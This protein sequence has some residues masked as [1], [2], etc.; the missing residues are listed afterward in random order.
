MARRRAQQG[1]SC[2]VVSRDACFLARMR[3]QSWYRTSASRSACKNG[4]GRAPIRKSTVLSR[5]SRYSCETKLADITVTIT[6]GYSREKRSMT[7]VSSPDAIAS[8]D[9]IRT[10]P[11][12]GSARVSMSLM[13]CLN[14]SNA[15][16]P[17]QRTTI[18]RRLHAFRAIKEPHAD[19]VLHVGDRLGYGRLRNREQLG[20]FAHAAQLG[21][22]QQNMQIVQLEPAADTVVP[23]RREAPSGCQGAHRY[24]VML[25]SKERI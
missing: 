3:A 16:A 12:V 21:N 14:S 9:P 8:G 6:R 2:A 25:R 5:S 10:S 15:A 20:G 11:L 4:V 13:P 1:Q 17:E 19:R 18:G 24:T 22:R 23:F 7:A